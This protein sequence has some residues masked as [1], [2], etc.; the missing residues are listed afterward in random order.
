MVLR[1][2]AGLLGDTWAEVTCLAYQNRLHFGE[3]RVQQ[4]LAVYSIG[5]TFNMMK[6]SFVWITCPAQMLTSVILHDESR[7]QV[8]AEEGVRC[9][10]IIQVLNVKEVSSVDNSACSN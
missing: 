9:F 7:L 1:T 3:V 4:Q 8:A 6:I 10:Q 5:W 2:L